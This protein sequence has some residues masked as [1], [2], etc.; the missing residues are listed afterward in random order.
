MLV[1]KTIIVAHILST[2]FKELLVYPL[3]SFIAE[4]GGTMGLFVG[5]SFLVIWDQLEKLITFVLR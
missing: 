1:Y 4:V 5:F 2:I 3:S